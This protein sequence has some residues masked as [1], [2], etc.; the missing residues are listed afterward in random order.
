MLNCWKRDQS[1][2]Y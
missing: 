1:N 2:N